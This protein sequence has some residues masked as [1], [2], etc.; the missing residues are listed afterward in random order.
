MRCWSAG[1]G[2]IQEGGDNQFKLN[3]VDIPIYPDKYDCQEKINR[4]LE[5]K[6]GRKGR[7]TNLHAGE[8]CFQLHPN[9]DL[10]SPFM[11]H[12]SLKNEELN[13]TVKKC[14]IHSALAPFS[15]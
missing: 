5:A 3:K 10:P 11:D 7:K 4:A 12:F 15:N 8:V 13:Q 1:F 2:A 9:Y 6:R 14:I